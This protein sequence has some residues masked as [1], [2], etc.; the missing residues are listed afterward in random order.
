VTGFNQERRRKQY[1][2]P[3]LHLP[4]AFFVKISFLSAGGI[5]PYCSLSWAF[6]IIAVA[7]AQEIIE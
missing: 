1:P 7:E 2:A 5:Q 3:F 4:S 6:S